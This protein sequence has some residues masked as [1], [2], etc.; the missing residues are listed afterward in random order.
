MKLSSTADQ[1][2]EDQ[3]YNDQRF[4]RIVIENCHF[5]RC[6]FSKASLDGC[7]FIESDFTGCN[8]SMTKPGQKPT[9]QAVDK[10]TILG[11]HPIFRG[12][13][14]ELINRLASYAI[15]QRV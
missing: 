14:T 1:V 9:S 10:R 3:E 5:I 8:F 6:D 15:A 7:D 13:E 12:L 2:F 4:D 11:G